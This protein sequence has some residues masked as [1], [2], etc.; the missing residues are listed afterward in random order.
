MHCILLV[1]PHVRQLL[2]VC[3]LHMAFPVP[4][5]AGHCLVLAGIVRSFRSFSAAEPPLVSV[6]ASS[7]RK[8]RALFEGTS[9]K[10]RDQNLS[11]ILD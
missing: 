10:A 2:P 11:G 3:E 8:N 5:H 7:D 1:P 6:D 4:Q 9:F